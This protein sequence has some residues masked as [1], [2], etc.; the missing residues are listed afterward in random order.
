[1]IDV[2]EH[3]GRLGAAGDRDP[4]RVPT[5]EAWRALSPQQREEVQVAINEAL[6]V[7]AEL[8]SEGQPHRRAKS[9][10]IDALGLHFRTI[11]RAVYLAEELAVLYPGERGFAP[12]ILAVLD[13]E[14]TEDDERLAW[15]VADEGKGPD[16]VLEVLHRGDRAK[17]LVENVER[18]ARLGIPEY[19]V[20]DRARQQI[21]GWL[22]RPGAA[23]Y[24]RQVP[25]RGHYRSNVLGL[26]LAILDD[27]LQFLSGEATL[28]LS[29]DLIGRLQ[30]LQKSLES[31]AEQA[32]ARA[33]QALAGGLREGLLAVLDVR[34][35]PCP[36]E[37]R[38]RLEACAEPA[39]LRHLLARAATAVR[40]D[41]VFEPTD[42]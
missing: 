41:E 19:F 42:R 38:A 26:D 20:Y 24:E 34:G 25:Q 12:D 3:A 13:V 35:I 27:N 21:H 33:D 22:L 1:V 23:R 6:T 2:P 17:D 29:T 4:L 11:G 32:Q 10:A 18:Y 16:L 39:V 40:V 36:D 14:Q 7:P 30:D 31:R 37:A 9:R 15:V 5:A 8:M 28:P